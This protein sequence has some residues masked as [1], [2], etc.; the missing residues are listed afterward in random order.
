MNKNKKLVRHL[1]V[2]Y[3]TKKGDVF[4][5]YNGYGKAPWKSA[6]KRDSH[7]NRHLRVNKLMDLD[8]IVSPKERIIAKHPIEKM[9]KEYKNRK[10]YEEK[11]RS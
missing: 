5:A 7:N 9:K 4:E 3:L 2:L 6:S 8:G 1:L 11:N 10:K